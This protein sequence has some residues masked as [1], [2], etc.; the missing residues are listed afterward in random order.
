MA[1]SLAPDPA[2]LVAVSFNRFE[3]RLGESAWLN[4]AWTV[5]DQR[6]KKTLAVRSS[7]LQEQVAGPGYAELVAAQSRLLGELSR[8]IAAELAAELKKP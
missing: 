2:Y 7:V 8:D 1:D 6:H 3:G 4:A 5:R